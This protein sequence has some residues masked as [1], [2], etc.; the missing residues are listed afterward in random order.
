MSNSNPSRPKLAPHL[1]YIDAR[2]VLEELPPWPSC[3][4][5]APTMGDTCAPCHPPSSPLPPRA[6][7]PAADEEGHQHALSI[8]LSTPCSLPLV[9]YSLPCSR[10]PWPVTQAR[11]RRV[12]TAP[13]PHGRSHVHHRL[14]LVV[15]H[16]TR[17]LAQ[18]IGHRSTA[19]GKLPPLAVVQAAGVRGQATSGLLGASCGHLR[20][21]VDPLVLPRPSAAD[22]MASSGRSSDSPA[23]LCSKFASG[24]SRDNSTKVKG[25]A[26]MS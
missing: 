1:A 5:R 17:T 4:G 13:S 26:A 20:V 18:A 10:P 19:A 3:D 8:P 14:C 16:L 22:G 9:L 12:L 24:T 11:C 6:L 7:R 21:R 23:I 15:L 2:H 25:L